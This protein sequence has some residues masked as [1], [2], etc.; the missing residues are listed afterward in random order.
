MTST[1]PLPPP[2]VSIPLLSTIAGQ[3]LR[4][5]AGAGRVVTVCL[6]TPVV[7]LFGV[8]ACVA[9]AVVGTARMA[10]TSA[11]SLSQS[12]RAAA[13]VQF[14]ATSTAER[15]ESVAARQAA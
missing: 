14:Y 8:V 10:Q 1:T 6:L 4:L 2:R 13:D 9:L 15:V 7:L 5:V 11:T 12:T 3:G